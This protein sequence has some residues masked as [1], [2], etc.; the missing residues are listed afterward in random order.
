MSSGTHE[1]QKIVARDARRRR[2]DQRVAVD[3]FIAHE[4]FVHHHAHALLIIVNEGQS[5]DRPGRHAE[6]FHEQLGFAEAQPRGADPLVQGFQIDGR[7][8]LGDDEKQLA[9]GV[10]QEEVLGMSALEV[11][12]EMRTLGDREDR[13][14]LDG[15]GL[16]AELGQTREKDFPGCRHRALTQRGR[17]VRP[18]RTR[19]IEA[20]A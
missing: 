13:L 8:A 9:L 16:D 11:A 17:S 15:H 6:H 1:T 19:S 20:A 5:R 10:L 3:P 18:I 7:M 12:L 4:A 14:V 2:V